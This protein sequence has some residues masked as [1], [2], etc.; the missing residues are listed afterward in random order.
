MRLLE[1]SIEIQRKITCKTQNDF[2]VL[3]G[4]QKVFWLLS[5]SFH[6]V[7]LHFEEQYQWF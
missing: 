7:F 3:K 6:C 1:K 5:K 4:H 2:V